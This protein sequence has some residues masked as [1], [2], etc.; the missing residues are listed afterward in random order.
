MTSM[1]P[2]NNDLLNLWKSPLANGQTLAPIQYPDAPA[3]PIVFVGINPSFSAKGWAALAK[4]N[5]SG[6]PPPENVF[7]WPQ[8]HF[9]QQHAIAWEIIAL[10]HYRYFNKFRGLARVV[11]KPWFHLD[12]FATRVTVQKSLLAQLQLKL[13]PLSLNSFGSAQLDLFDKAL[14]IVRPCA[15]IVANSAAAQI[16]IQ[17]RNPK[18][19]ANFCCYVD[20]VGTAEQRTEFPM[21]PSGMWSGGALDIYS[22]ERIFCQVAKHFGRSQQFGKWRSA[23][24]TLELEENSINDL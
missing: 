5:T 7:L 16:Y 19:D 2:I 3:N 10:K 4:Y 15:V 8:L 12:L 11:G 22:I 9:N 24:M 21:F 17:R 1:M 14:E 20:A 18:F 13:N 6:L 23:P